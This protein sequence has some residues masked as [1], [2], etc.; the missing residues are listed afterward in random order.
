MNEREYEAALAKLQAAITDERGELLPISRLEFEIL[1]EA[2]V[3][4]WNLWQGSQRL[5]TA[6]G[7]ASDVTGFL[8]ASKMIL[9]MRSEQ[10]TKV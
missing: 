7:Q 6:T 4:R 2:G 1:D 5:Y 8:A 10:R 9:E 3:V